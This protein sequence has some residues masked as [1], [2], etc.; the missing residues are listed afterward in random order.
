MRRFTYYNLDAIISIGYRVNSIVGVRFRQWAT[1]IIKERMFQGAVQVA[2]FSARA[3]RRRSSRRSTATAR[4]IPAARFPRATSRR[5]T[6]S[7][8]RSPSPIHRVV[9]RPLPRRRRQGAVLDR[10]L[11]QGPRQEVLRVHEV[12]RGRNPPHQEN[13]VRVGSRR[14]TR[15]QLTR[16]VGRHRPRRPAPRPFQSGPR[17]RAQAPRRTRGRVS[18]FGA[19]PSLHGNAARCLRAS[20]AASSAWRVFSIV[21][22][23]RDRRS[24]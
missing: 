16:Q 3:S 21:S 4:A 1:K 20:R 10:S 8:R 12:G 5:S 24:S 7:T 11:S 13:S 14:P 17:R 6:D 9:P 22:S 18:R 23:I 15:P 19:D 2:R